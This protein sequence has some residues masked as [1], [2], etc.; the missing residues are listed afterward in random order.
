MLNH[1]VVVDGSKLGV[2]YPAATLQNLLAV[3]HLDADRALHKDWL[4]DKAARRLSLESMERS[5]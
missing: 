1:N 2:V 5:R 3:H 4:L